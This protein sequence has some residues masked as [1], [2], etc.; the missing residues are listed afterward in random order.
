MLLNDPFC[1]WPTK[2]YA[3]PLQG[4]R[5]G[6]RDDRETLVKIKNLLSELVNREVGA[7]FD[8]KDHHE[9]SYSISSAGR[10]TSR[11]YGREII[12]P[13]F[14]TRPLPNS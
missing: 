6:V 4:V 3:N 12:I 14:S 5:G 8:S 1:L 13:I 11:P 9:S 2:P 7:I 10:F